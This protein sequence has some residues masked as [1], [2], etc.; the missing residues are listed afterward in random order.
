[1]AQPDGG[2]SGEAVGL[3]CDLVQGEGPKARCGAGGCD[4]FG[5][6]LSVSL[7]PAPRGHVI[8]TAQ[9]VPTC[10]CPGPALVR[11]GLCIWGTNLLA[12]GWGGPGPRFEPPQSFP[13]S[14]GNGTCEV[15]TG[16]YHTF[17]LSVSS[18]LCLRL[19]EG[20]D[21]RDA[22]SLPPRVRAQV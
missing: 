14:L 22:P 10:R 17:V 12:Q 15:M 4:P 9:Q 2:G 20:T 1:M 11:P 13:W 18:R 19:R 16:G 6:G 21:D 5:A 3:G 8:M 7:G